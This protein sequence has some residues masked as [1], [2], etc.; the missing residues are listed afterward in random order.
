MAVA[1]VAG[2]VADGLP[3]PR[4]GPDASPRSGGH[5]VPPEPEPDAPAMLPRAA[6]VAPASAPFHVRLLVRKLDEVEAA[7]A[8]EGGSA[9]ARPA[10]PPAAKRRKLRSGQS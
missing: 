1:A 8:A 6:A 7:P 3:S 10:K 9:T 5:L 4:P 2:L